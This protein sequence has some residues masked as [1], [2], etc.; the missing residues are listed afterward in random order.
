MEWFAKLIVFLL[1]GLL[2]CVSYIVSF[3]GIRSPIIISE[4]LDNRGEV[5]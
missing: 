3:A 5:R 1:V 4:Q 2:G